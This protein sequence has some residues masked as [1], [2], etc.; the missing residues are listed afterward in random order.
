M[1]IP[2]NIRI[3]DVRSILFWPASSK[4]WRDCKR[5]DQRFYL[6]NLY[7][8]QQPNWRKQV[9]VCDYCF[10]LMS[11]STPPELSLLWR[12]LKKQENLDRIVDDLIY[13]I[14][15]EWRNDNNRA[16]VSAIDADQT[17]PD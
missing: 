2:I 9:P 15:R 13:V 1:D 11:I 7:S 14:E 8:S 5:C 17:I 6:P 3:E 4:D 10:N 12:L 16:V